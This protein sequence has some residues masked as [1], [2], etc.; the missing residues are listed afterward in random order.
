MIVLAHDTGDVRLDVD[1][2]ALC[3]RH[4]KYTPPQ[5]GPR[6]R[7]VTYEEFSRDPRGAMAGRSTL[8]VVGLGAVVTPANRTKTFRK[9]FRRPDDWQKISVDRTLFVSEPWRAWWHFG[10]V[11]ARYREYTYSYLAE[12]HWRAYVDGARTDDPFALPVVV[13]HGCGVVTSTYDRYFDPLEIERVAVGADEHATYRQLKAQCFDQEHT[14]SAIL[15]RLE[16][17]A[18][19]VCP[20]RAVPTP[21]RLF[22][23]T[24]H[25]VVQTDLP[26]DDF[27]VGRLRALVELTDG[28]G[29]AFRAG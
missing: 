7:H 20:N 23:R 15:K 10:V 16:T 9:F 29:R 12:S 28:I 1:G 2:E 14:L 8:V 18:A 21:A 26:V 25:R 17:F 22:G 19:R 5:T 3:V 24:R 13:E 4:S 11:G 6:C 27:L